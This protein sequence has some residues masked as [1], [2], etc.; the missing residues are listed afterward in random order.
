MAERPDARRLAVRTTTGWTGV[1]VAA[2]VT[3]VVGCSA[4]LPSYVK[5]RDHWTQDTELY[6]DF[7][8]RIFIDATL[9]TEDFR[10]EYV[11]EYGRIFALPEARQ[12]TMLDAEL[13][14]AKD[15]WVI[16]AAI[17]VNKIQWDKFDPAKGIWEVRLESSDGRRGR[18]IKA[19]KHDT[20][21][22]TWKAL[23]PYLGPHDS[24]WEFRFERTDED[25]APLVASGE[26][27]T[28]VIAGAP[29]RV[30]LTWRIP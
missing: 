3:T 20:D 10:R 12:Q 15:Q 18:L 13:A 26:E 21:N 6:E 30:D 14:E 29:G 8:S 19:K 28:L 2:A 9:K 7:E 16:V 5:A 1:L 25:G 27:V 4:V 22:P 23:Y 11:K 17:F 24:L